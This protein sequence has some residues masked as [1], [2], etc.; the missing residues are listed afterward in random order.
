MT[1]FQAESQK[2]YQDFLK[3]ISSQCYDILRDAIN[4]LAVADCL[5]SL[6]RVSSNLGYVKPE[7]TDDNSLEIIEG[8]HPLVDP[9]ISNSVTM[10]FGQPRS[11]I[12]TGPN[13]GGYVTPIRLCYLLTP[14]FLP[15]YS[16]SSFV[17]MVALIVLMAQVGSYVPAASVRMGLHDSIL[18]RMG[19]G[20]LYS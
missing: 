17:R 10:G 18:T 15:L 1:S 6:A 3:D 11:K 20:C 8:Q 9:C 4:K 13:M 2:A 16:K 12:I 7:F 5:N 19:G 14:N